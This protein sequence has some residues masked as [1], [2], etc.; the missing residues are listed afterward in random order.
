LYMKAFKK[1]FTSA[2]RRI[3]I[4]QW[5]TLDD[6]VNFCRMTI[7]T[8]TKY[9]TYLFSSIDMTIRCHQL[10]TNTCEEMLF[11]DWCAY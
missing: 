5:L 8:S 9:M 2:R 1:S 3:C 11:S 10:W 7:L 4:C 6:T